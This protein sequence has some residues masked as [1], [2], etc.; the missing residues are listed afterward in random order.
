M[1]IT[2]E[3]DG[4][5]LVVEHPVVDAQIRSDTVDVAC[6]CPEPCGFVHRVLAPGCRLTFSVDLP[7]RPQW[8]KS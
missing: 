7:E 5:R 8:V 3:Q 4:Y 6:D 1:K 2:L